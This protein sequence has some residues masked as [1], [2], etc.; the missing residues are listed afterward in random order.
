MGAAMADRV[1]QQ[2]GDYRLIRQLGEGSFGTVYL[3]QH[4]LLQSF[5][6]VKVLKEGLP[7]D[8]LRLLLAEARRVA[9]LN[10]PNITRLLGFSLQDNIPFMVMQLAPHGSLKEGLPTGRGNERFP[11]GTLLPIKRI[12][13]YVQQAA[14]GLQYA[15]DKGIIHLDIKPENMLLGE[16]GEVLLADFGIAVALQE[17]THKTLRGVT[18]WV[19]SAAYAAPEQFEDGGHVSTV[20]D[21]YELAVVIYEWLTGDFP[22]RGTGIAIG[23]QKQLNP[24][25]PLRDKVPTISPAVEKEVLTALAKDPKKR[26]PSVRAFATALEQASLL[27]QPTR[28]S[29]APLSIAPKSLPS[30]PSVQ[31]QPENQSAPSWQNAPTWITPQPP[32]QPLTQRAPAQP[33]QPQAETIPLPWRQ[34]TV[35]E[36][37]SPRFSGIPSGPVA[38]PAPESTPPRINRR[39]ARGL[40][41]GVLAL[42]LVS[43]SLVGLGFAGK[44]PLASLEKLILGAV[45]EFALPP[46]YSVNTTTT[47]TGSFGITNGP[48]G[49][50]WFT[51]FHG[52]NIG[53]ITPEGEIAEF[54][55]P[56]IYQ[57]IGI[58]IGRD[59]NLWF[60]EYGKIGRITPTGKITEFPIIP[61]D[62]SDPN[63]IV[64]GPD[65]NL[66]FTE[67]E[68]NK[69]G[70]ITL[71]G[72]VTEFAVPT[73]SSYPIGIT[74]GPDGNLW[75]TEEHTNK[76]GRIAP[77]GQIKEFSVPTAQSD[78]EGITKG[79]DGNLW[80]TERNGNKIGRISPGL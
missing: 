51:E 25:P 35:P 58:T 78:L 18:G 70:R 16:Q 44:G 80:F 74:K 31:V 41:L 30:T 69:I 54:T 64:A 49:N 37:P 47:T 62:Q 71:E 61:D 46:N 12:L 42:V 59:S 4:V 43:S 57:P 28:I 68:G 29:N 3:G 63:D 21:Q 34:Q 7:Q 79:P 38:L 19:G 36:A 48:D 53:R 66:W 73:A 11:K 14:A 72:E 65:G 6:A 45:K 55:T 1:G 8:E 17:Q 75:F 2:F 56:Q 50:L 13:P 5:A 52:N 15:H 39:R 23:T 76:I 26:F 77:T 32:A 33:L 67:Y 24:P 27:D 10:H 20:S 60:A 40:L 9:T 22:F